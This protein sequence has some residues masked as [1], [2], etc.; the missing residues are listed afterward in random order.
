MHLTRE[1]FIRG[2]MIAYRMAI[3]HPE[4]VTHI[5]TAC[6][7]HILLSAEWVEPESLTKIYPTL[8]YQFQF[9]SGLIE[10]ETRTK[11]GIHKVLNA[12]YDGRTSDNQ[13]AMNPSKGVDFDLAARLEKT[14][15]LSEEELEYYVDEF[16]RNGLGAACM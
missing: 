16:A 7:P 2:A 3:W 13:P 8:G 12:M 1:P 15:L 4:F 14:A 6:V 10:Q 11:R 5:F 9:G